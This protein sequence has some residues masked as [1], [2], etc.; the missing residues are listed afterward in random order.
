[1]EGRNL[2]ERI[3]QAKLASLGP[4]SQGPGLCWAVASPAARPVELDGLSSPLSLTEVEERGAGCWTT[5]QEI[6]WQ[7]KF[8][9]ACLGV[10]QKLDKVGQ[11]SSP[12]LLPETASALLPPFL[13]PDRRS[14]LA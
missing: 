3:W 7:D 9:I 1:M 8:G 2:R 12:R 6:R 14:S 10:D 4:D 5:E 11:P 13:L